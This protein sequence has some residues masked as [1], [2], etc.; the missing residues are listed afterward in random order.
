[1][2]DIKTE[3]DVQSAEGERLSEIIDTIKDDSL[4]IEDALSLL[5]EAIKIGNEACN[6]AS[7]ILSNNA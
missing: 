1:M 5:D 7:K 4:P 3:N 2:D 6:R